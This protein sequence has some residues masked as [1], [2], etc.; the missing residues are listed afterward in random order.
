MITKRIEENEEIKV[1]PKKAIAKKLEEKI[2]ETSEMDVLKKKEDNGEANAM[3]NTSLKSRKDLI[4]IIKNSPPHNAISHINILSF[5]V[6]VFL[7]TL[8]SV[9]YGIYTSKYN[10]LTSDLHIF[11]GSCDLESQI[12]QA[13]EN[14]R[15]LVLVNAGNLT[16]YENYTSQSDYI[17]ALITRFLTIQSNIDTTQKQL[18]DLA[19]RYSNLNSAL[20]ADTTLPIQIKVGTNYKT[21]FYN[22]IEALI[23]YDSFIIKIA[24]TA[25][26]TKFTNDDESVYFIWQNGLNAIFM[27]LRKALENLQLDFNNYCNNF[28]NI[29]LILMIISYGV[30]IFGCLSVVPYL[31]NV[32]VANQ[33]I[34]MLFFKIKKAYAKGFAKKCQ[35]FLNSIEKKHNED[36]SEEN[37]SERSIDD[38]KADDEKEGMLQRSIRQTNTAGGKIKTSDDILGWSASQLSIG[39]LLGL[40]FLASYLFFLGLS[41]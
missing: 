10:E 34:L 9:E 31:R 15:N 38:E 5:L 19:K 20:I 40:Y 33:E 2:R 12:A 29:M 30:V 1:V 41:L 39:L 22:L 6:V 4:E 14:T 37:E 32:K 11:A 7:I 24:N 21:Q 23:I 25:S 26:T 8:D 28:A 17:N 36:E 18:A 27:S 13:V 16:T 3:M 35:Q